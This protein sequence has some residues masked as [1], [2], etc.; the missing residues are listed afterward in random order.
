EI[1]PSIRK[2]GAYIAPNT[3]DNIISDPDFGIKLLTTLKEER[4]RRIEAEN[5]KERA[6]NTIL[7][8]KPKAD[9]VDRVIE[10]VQEK[11]DVGQAAK[12]LKLSFGRNTFFKKLRDMGVFFKNR[13]E[14]KQEYVNK[15]YFELVEKDIPRDNHPSFMVIKVLIT[16]KGLLWL[17]GMFNGNKCDNNMA[18]FI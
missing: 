4:S 3:L 1:L 11:V 14:P 12:L 18:K 15:G 10:T 16:Q 6:E 13:N 9:F 5:G 17:D 2:H 7:A 8:L